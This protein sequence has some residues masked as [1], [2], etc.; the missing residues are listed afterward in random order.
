LTDA[1]NHNISLHD[2]PEESTKDNGDLNWANQSLT[3][4]AQLLK[5]ASHKYNALPFSER[6]IDR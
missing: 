3:P 1:E 2:N 6:T 5:P 4:Q